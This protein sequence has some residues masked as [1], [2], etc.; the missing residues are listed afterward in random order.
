MSGSTVVLGELYGEIWYVM[1]LLNGF[2]NYGG[3]WP[4]ASAHYLNKVVHIRGVLNA[5]NSSVGNP[6]CVL[7]AAYRPTANQI[8]VVDAFAGTLGPTRRIDILTDG[9][10]L[11][12]TGDLTAAKYFS[13][14][15]IAYRTDY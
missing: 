14:C 9:T 10:I 5:P 8:F 1:S 11:N 6:I 15:G 7:P 12:P 4:P 13:L 2:S 3:S